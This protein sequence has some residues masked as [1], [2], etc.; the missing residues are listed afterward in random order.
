MDGSYGYEFDEY[1]A[2]F[3]AAGP[4]AGDSLDSDSYGRRGRGRGE[5][6]AE[7]EVGDGAG[8][9][10]GGGGTAKPAF[11]WSAFGQ[12]RELEEQ[13]AEHVLE[14]D[15]L[16]RDN[17]RLRAKVEDLAEKAARKFQPESSERA[18]EPAAGAGAYDMRDAK[19]VKLTKA[20]RSLTVALER[21]RTRSAT[22]QTQLDATKPGFEFAVAHLPPARAAEFRQL[23]GGQTVVSPAKKSSGKS[24]S[25][26]GGAGP[27]GPDTGAGRELAKSLSRAQARNREY[28]LVIEKLKT[29]LK[30]TQ[31]AL[32]REVGDNVP[33]EEVLVEGSGWRGRAETIS[34]LSDK[35]RKLKK[36]LAAGVN[37]LD[38]T[39]VPTATSFD[40]KHASTIRAL[41][42]SKVDQIM[43]LERTIEMQNTELS[44][45][46][47][48]IRGKASRTTALEKDMKMLREKVQVLLSKTSNDDELIQ[49]LQAKLSTTQA[50]LDAKPRKYGASA[51]GR[52]PFLTEVPPSAA[53]SRNGRGPRRLRPLSGPP[54][55][56]AKIDVHTM[57]EYLELEKQAKQ[58]DGALRETRKQVDVQEK[59]VLQ[60]QREVEDLHHTIDEQAHSL[61]QADKELRELRD[62]AADARA[63]ARAAAMASVV[64]SPGGDKAERESRESREAGETRQGHESRKPREANKP[65]VYVA[66]PELLDVIE[67]KTNLEALAH[68]NDEL[69]AHIDSLR[70]QLDETHNHSLKLESVRASLASQLQSAKEALAAKRSR[71]PPRRLQLALDTNEALKKTYAAQIDS[72]DDELAM[73]HSLLNETRASFHA[74]LAEVKERVETEIEENR[75]AREQ[76]HNSRFGHGRRPS[77]KP[78]SSLKQK[79]RRS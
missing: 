22:L 41:E 39:G 1:D 57:P 62:E 24:S 68:E 64:T 6:E 71:E 50:A 77:Q 17:A 69:S 74:A 21:E 28:R 14:L 10:T 23:L 32:V 8:A 13:N 48:K 79:S 7:V 3:A 73:Y 44:E 20:K 19:I 36:Q 18:P 46:K 63:A 65:G 51:T 11:D 49:A 25:R 4:P 34:L 55:R 31:R 45:L 33:L 42:E 29:E 72:K 47:L 70:H 54:K 40:D 52:S 78:R 9:A 30:A 5:V 27:P 37:Y 53:S 12:V 58:L 16:R 75:A 76:D 15:A 61:S 2:E 38:Q 35:I 26:S 60:L 66:H 43:R 56:P 59:I 67:L